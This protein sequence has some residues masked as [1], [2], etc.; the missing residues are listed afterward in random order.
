MRMK[1]EGQG[2]LRQWQQGEQEVQVG[3]AVAGKWT[4]KNMMQGHEHKEQR[5]AKGGRDMGSKLSGEGRQ[6]EVGQHNR[7]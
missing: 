5:T 7:P 6:E 1:N 3:G 2:A 4:I